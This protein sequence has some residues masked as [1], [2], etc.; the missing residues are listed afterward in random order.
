MLMHNPREFERVAREWSVRYAGAPKVEMG[1]SSG[2]A[3]KETLKQVRKKSKE[4][5]ERERL[6]AYAIDLLFGT[7]RAGQAMWGDANKHMCPTAMRATTKTLSIALSTWDSTSIESSRPSSSSAS[8]RTTARTTSL[9]KPTWAISRP[10]YW[11]S[12]RLTV[13]S[14][15]AS[16][17]ETRVARG[18][19]VVPWRVMHQQGLRGSRVVQE[20]PVGSWLYIFE[21]RSSLKRNVF[22]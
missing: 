5:E 6:A 3:T 2:G 14:L 17:F 19:R 13:I 15:K 16:L 1:E 10:G 8:T 18:V 22:V 4:E 21:I 11:G 20:F 9:R 7:R 12:P